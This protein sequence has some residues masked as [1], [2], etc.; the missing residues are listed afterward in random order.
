[1]DEH[2]AQLKEKLDRMLTEAAELQVELGQ[3]DGSV[4]PANTSRIRLHSSS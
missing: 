3:A 2:V 4:S 1:M